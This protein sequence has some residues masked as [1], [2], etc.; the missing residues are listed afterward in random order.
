MAEQL[1]LE[2]ALRC[3][4]LTAS[5]ERAEVPEAPAGWAARAQAALDTE[6]AAEILD[7]ATQIAMVHSQYS[8]DWDHKGWLFDLRAVL[9]RP[10]RALAANN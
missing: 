4:V 10:R 8:A 6:D 7:C 9:Y 3:A 5:E 2:D 1:T